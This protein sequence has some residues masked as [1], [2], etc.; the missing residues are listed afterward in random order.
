MAK[1]DVAHHRGTLGTRD[2]TAG[3]GGVLFEEQSKWKVFKA[4]YGHY[5]ESTSAD[6]S[7]NTANPDDAKADIQVSS[8][9]EPTGDR[10]KQYSEI[11][12]VLRGHAR[13]CDP[14][15]LRPLH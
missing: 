9:V 5:I 6:A 10:V 7:T 13:N 2:A 1:S 11:L 3:R 8:A 14:L 4:D 15:V 12:H